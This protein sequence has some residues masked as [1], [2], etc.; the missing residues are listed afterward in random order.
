M[1][2]AIAKKWFVILPLLFLAMPALA[3]E[4]DPRRW[5]H[6]PMNANFAGGGYVYTT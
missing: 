5:A 3:D 1:L 2:T 6:L 4:L